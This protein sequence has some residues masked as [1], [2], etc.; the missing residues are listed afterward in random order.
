MVAAVAR[1]AARIVDA[2]GIPVGDGR[3]RLAGCAALRRIGVAHTTAATQMVPRVAHDTAGVVRASGLA[4]RCPGT[5]LALR[6]ALVRIAV[7]GANYGAW[8]LVKTL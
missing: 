8:A 7:A 6:T 2:R 1:G 4:I 3:A 5:L